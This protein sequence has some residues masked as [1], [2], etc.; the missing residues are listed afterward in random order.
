MENIN[1]DLKKTEIMAR[2]MVDNNLTLGQV[3]A[4][5][6]IS[7]STLQSRFKNVLQTENLLLYLGVIKQELNNGEKGRVLGGQ[8]G[9]KGRVKWNDDDA[10]KVLQE[11]EKK[12]MSI[13]ALADKLNIPKSRLFEMLAY[14]RNLRIENTRKSKK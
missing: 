4:K 2:D 7:K 6:K 12:E 5:Y 9:H 11:Y 1:D 10:I 13:R 14:A 8:N 3:S